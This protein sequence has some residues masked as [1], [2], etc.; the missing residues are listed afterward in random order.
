MRHAI[1]SRIFRW[2]KQFRAFAT[3]YNKTARNFLAAF[4]MIAALCWLN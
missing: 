4:H 1:C 3:R 2:V